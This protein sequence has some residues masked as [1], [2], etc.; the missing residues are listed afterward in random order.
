MTCFSGD[1][2]DVNQWAKY[3]KGNGYAIGF[4]PRGLNREP[5]SWLYR[6]VYDKVKQENAAKTIAEATL[7]F[8]QEGLNEERM[9]DPDCWAR[10][11]FEAWDE[12]VYKL[13][14]LAKDP[15]WKGESEYRIVDE[16]KLAEFPNVRFSQKKTM[17]SRYLALDFPC[18]V[19][20][21]PRYYRS[22]R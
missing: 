5:T 14:P 18:W 4:L 6:V 12:W 11:F 2:D 17:L 10:E 20:R 19:K 15:K 3:A 13:A 16:L 9:K 22:R 1:G 21:L 7:R 8:Y